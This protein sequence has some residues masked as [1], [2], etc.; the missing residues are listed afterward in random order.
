MLVPNVQQLTTATVTRAAA[1]DAQNSRIRTE[2][3]HGATD[4]GYR[5]LH[6]GSLAEPFFTS[7]YPRDWVA[8][9]VSKW[10][11]VDRIH[12]L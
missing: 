4:V 12:R 6:I 5:P 11:D 8:A 3:A 7:A 1:W 9:C 10:Y 2:A